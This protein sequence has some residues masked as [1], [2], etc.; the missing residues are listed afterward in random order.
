MIARLLSKMPA[1]P[2]R[3]AASARQRWGR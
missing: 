2:A 1:K 3:L